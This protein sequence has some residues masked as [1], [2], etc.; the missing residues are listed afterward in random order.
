MSKIKM[1]FLLT[2]VLL[3]G[4]GFAGILD[5]DPDNLRG[6]VLSQNG[7]TYYVTLKETVYRGRD[8]YDLYFVENL[9]SLND[10][11]ERI[12]ELEGRVE[13]LDERIVE[14]NSTISGL[15]K[16]NETATENLDSLKEEKNKLEEQ[17]T[18]LEERKTE[19]KSKV[20]DNF[21]IPRI[22]F[23]SI[24]VLAIIIF[25]ISVYYEFRPPSKNKGKED[26]DDKDKEAYS[27]DDVVV[28]E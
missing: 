24:V 9:S 15:N 2:V 18:K 13:F 23:L 28:I 26:K 10:I 25:L 16:K 17:L 11:D 8:T 22:Q 4:I 5:L 19:L 14:L 27:S 1:V 12:S 20:E 3:S 6:S 21:L 7:S